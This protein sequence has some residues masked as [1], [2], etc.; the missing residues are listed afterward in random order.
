MNLSSLSIVIPT[1]NEGSTIG[2]TIK[3]IAESVVQFCSDYEIIV[4]DDG[5]RDGTAE[6]VKKFTAVYPVRFLANNGNAG[7]GAAVKRGV[8][9]A[10]KKLVL[11]MDADNSARLIEVARFLPFLSDYDIIIGSRQLTGG[12]IARQ[13][14]KHRKFV[15]QCFN[16]LVRFVLGLN[17]YD[18]QCGFKL[19]SLPAAR[20]VFNLMQ[21]NGFAFDVELL[22]I[23]NRLGL[24]VKEVGI[25]WF[26][27][28][29]KSEVK[30]L[31][32]SIN[33]FLVVLIIKYRWYKL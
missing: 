14:F 21:E 33:M 32:H 23:A 16:H 17:F 25:S 3:D 19:M 30:I 26:R 13:E 8:A 22:Y 7:K 20:R 5:S 9:V 10:S 4:S 18:T 6:V 28:N 31:K 15:G 24:T 1:Y 29:T 11:F 12:N 2:N 27:S